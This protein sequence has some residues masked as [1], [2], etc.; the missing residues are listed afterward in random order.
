MVSKIILINTLYRVTIQLLLNLTL[1][2]FLHAQRYTYGPV[3]S[4]QQLTNKS[5]TNKC[6]NRSD[7][8]FVF[9]NVIEWET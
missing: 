2:I 1:L 8:L 9:K 4:F 6:L 3:Y 7:F 5:I